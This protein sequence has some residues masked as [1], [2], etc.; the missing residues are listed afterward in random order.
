MNKKLISSCCQS[1]V[2]KRTFKKVGELENYICKYCHKP[3]EVIE[4]PKEEVKQNEFEKIADK[5][6]EL[7]IDTNNQVT[8]V[9]LPIPQPIQKEEVK[10]EVNYMQVGRMTECGH[11]HPEKFG[12]GL[13]ELERVIPNYKCD[14]ICHDKTPTTSD[15]FIESKVKE[16]NNLGFNNIGNKAVSDKMI[17]ILKSSLQEQRQSILEEIEKI[18]EQ[19][20]Q[21]ERFSGTPN[22][23]NRLLEDIK[24]LLKDNK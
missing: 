19:I 3:C 20:I 9:G 16:W 18:G 22:A 7:S 15:T 12:E 10:E 17:E 8:P 6:K 23:I 13:K 21:E 14:C 4:E 24:Q 1:E 11:C 5:A 2:E